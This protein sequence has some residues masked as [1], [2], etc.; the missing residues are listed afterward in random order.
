MTRAMPRVVAAA[1]VAL[2]CAALLRAQARDSRSLDAASQQATGPASGK[3]PKEAAPIDLTGYWVSIVTEDWRFR[4]VTAPKGDYPNVPLNA[5]GKKVADAW[6][7]AKD[8]KTDR[9]KAYGAPN[10]MRVPGRFHIT[11]ADDRTLR[12]ETDAGMQTRLLHFVAANPQSGAP[13][14]LQRQGYSAANWEGKAALKVVT[15]RLQ[16]GYL[17]TNG[18]PYSNKA[19]MMEFFDV[20]NEP[21]GDQWLIINT[22]VDDPT[23]LTRTFVRSTHFRKQADGSGWDPSPCLVR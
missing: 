16:D 13:P 20:V 21:N 2:G 1:V 17:Q 18:V 9:C 15:T 22:I 19:A 7:P 12:I 4:M 5:E 14:P 23:Y 6:D 10:I 8:E 11:W 3:S